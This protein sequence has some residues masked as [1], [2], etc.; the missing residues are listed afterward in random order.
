MTMKASQEAESIPQQTAEVAWRMSRKGTLPMHLRDGLGTIYQDRDFAQLFPHWGR[1]A[2]APWRLALV[3]VLQEIEGL[4]DRQAAQMV[5]VRIDWRYALSMTLEEPGFDFSILSDFRARLLEHH[6]ADRLLEPILALCRERG[7]LGG[8]GKQRTDSTM[9]LAHLRALSS[10]ESVG[11]GMRAALNAIAEQ[12]ADW[13]EEQ[14]NPAWFDRYVHRF[15]LAR[16]PKQESKRKQLRQDVGN[17]VQQLLT[18]IEQAALSKHLQAI[19]E[20]QLLRQ[21]FAQHYEVQQGQVNWRDGPAVSNEERVISPYD[22]DARSSRKRD[23]VWTGYKVHLTETCDQDPSRP[24]LVVGVETVPAT[25]QDSE[26]L[27]VISEHLRERERAPVEQYVDQGYSSGPQLIEQA[28]QGTLIVGP[29]PAEG[30]WQ[31]AKP[32]GYAAHDFELDWDRR[33]ATCPQGQ[34][35]RNWSQRTDERQQ[36]IELIRFPVTV[37]GK[38][39][40]REH[41]TKGTKQGRS[42]NLNV[43]E[44]H[45]ALEQ[46]RHEQFQ[47]EFLQRYALRAGIEGTISQGVRVFRL[48]QT[49]Y[50]GTAKTHL[51][52]LA[53]ASGLNL[54][55]IEAHL[56]AQAH[57]KPTRPARHPTPF[58][59]I[60]D[61]WEARGA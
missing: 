14:V 30:G 10:L 50:V 38:C 36:R 26:M 57:G 32:Q 16:F 56:Q 61:R 23:T 44:V 24:H 55:R 25:T 52:H 15:E 2:H 45:Q 34:Q 33:I 22:A 40:V 46:R 48:R 41:C 11:E 6:A 47:P 37:C 17:D 8:G 53:M 42:L 1:P 54:L 21:L 19:P 3:T 12:Q 58:A 35:T 13:L 18:L 51:H 39:P 31:A 43:Q 60:H 9:V 27:A 20:V 5:Q 29:V 49:P 59:C 28:R 7:W 4:T